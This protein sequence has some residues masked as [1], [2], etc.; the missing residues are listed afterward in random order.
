MRPSGLMAVLGASGLPEAT[1]TSYEA[2]LK[3]LWMTAEQLRPDGNLLASLGPLAPPCMALPYMRMRAKL[4]DATQAILGDMKSRGTPAEWADFERVCGGGKLFPNA[5]G[6]YTGPIDGIMSLPVLTTYWKD[7]PAKWQ[8]SFSVP[9]PPSAHG[10]LRGLGD[11]ETEAF[12]LMDLSGTPTVP[13]ASM[14][15]R[16]FGFA[17]SIYE[18]RWFKVLRS[19]GRVFEKAMIVLFIVDFAWEGA[20]KIYNR[21]WSDSPP[22]NIAQQVDD[23]ISFFN[24]EYQPEVSQQKLGVILA[25]ASAGPGK[26][27][28]LL[29]ALLAIDPWALKPL[30]TTGGDSD[31]ND[32]AWSDLLPGAKRTG[33]P[34]A[35]LGVFLG[36]SMADLTL[37]RYG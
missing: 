31:G 13:T 33:N 7:A 18:A 37:A 19:A 14:V 23:A 28:A 36:G 6:P 27:A 17:R 16:A 24:N 32:G 26:P 22:P 34:W 3:H 25:L 35:A 20:R 15:T 5:E 4:V 11:A 21:I 9:V 2:R 8:A 29:Q 1:A 10:K 30:P 12:E